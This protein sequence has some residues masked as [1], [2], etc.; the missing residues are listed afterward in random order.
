[1]PADTLRRS[2]IRYEQNHSTHDLRPEDAVTA[3]DPIGNPD[4][5]DRA[6]YLPNMRAN[7]QALREGLNDRE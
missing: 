2:L 5:P 7:L 4:Q 3:L 1:M 6:G